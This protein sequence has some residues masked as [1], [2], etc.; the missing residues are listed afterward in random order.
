MRIEHIALWASNLEALKDFYIKYFNATA[1][2][3]YH[4][5]QKDFRSYFLT[6]DGGARLEI[7]NAPGLQALDDPAQQYFG[8]CHLAMDVGSKDDVIQLTERLRADGHPVVSE[9]RTT[10]DGYFESVVLD[11]EGNR[12]EIVMGD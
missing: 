8:C 7:M 11:P 3:G 12:I 5:V 4:N 1:N 9:P 2:N 10:G 6:F